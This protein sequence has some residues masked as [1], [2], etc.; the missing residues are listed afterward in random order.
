M[1]MEALDADSSA[2]VLIASEKRHGDEFHDDSSTFQQ[3]RFGTLP[4]DSET[5]E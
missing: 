2:H 3:K 4:Q 5:S 1:R